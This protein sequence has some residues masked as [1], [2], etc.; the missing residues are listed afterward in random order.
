ML[1]LG[2]TLISIY[3]SVFNQNGNTVFDKGDLSLI[4]KAYIC[5]SGTV[6][7][8]VKK[9]GIRARDTFTYKCNE[10]NFDDDGMIYFGF[11][12]GRMGKPVGPI[13]KILLGNRY[14]LI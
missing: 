3:I 10:I 1:I 7:G 12:E 13:Y 2:V 6:C 4:V 8:Y 5:K 9:Y 14:S 11:H